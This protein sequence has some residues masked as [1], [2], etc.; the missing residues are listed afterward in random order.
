MLRVDGS[1]TLTPY[2][3]FGFRCENRST[4]RQDTDFHDA[5]TTGVMLGVFVR[6]VGVFVRDVH[7]HTL[8]LDGVYVKSDDG[9]RRFLRL[10]KPSAEEVYDVA[11]RTAEKVVAM[12]E[13]KGSSA[14]GASNDEGE[15]EIEAALLSCYDIAGRAPKTRIVDGPR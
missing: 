1:L 14:D 10:P 11:F 6:Y 8:A 9:G 2:H 5:Q 12:L 4:L 7:L 15:S 3:A 13:K